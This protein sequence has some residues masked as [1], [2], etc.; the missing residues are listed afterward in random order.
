MP[1]LLI[2]GI[3]PEQIRSVSKPLTEELAAICSCPAD[4]FMLECL[5]TTAIAGGEFAPSY[6]FIE[7]AWFDRGL[8][9]QDRFAEAVDRHIRQGLGLPELELA[10]RVY[11][12]RDYYSAGRSLAEP[13]EARQQAEAEAAHPADEELE[14]LRAANRKLAEELQRTRKALVSAS[15]SAMSTRLRDA[16]RE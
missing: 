9:A 14:E 10:F 5:H 7:I 3:A 12:A 8:E 1:H 13:T 15:G 6:P 2:R 4:D 16:L 11:R